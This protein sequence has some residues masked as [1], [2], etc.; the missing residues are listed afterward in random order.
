MYLVLQVELHDVGAPGAPSVCCVPILAEGGDGP[1]TPLELQDALPLEAFLAPV[2]ACKG[3]LV[4]AI[5]SLEA[6][7]P[8]NDWQPAA[9]S[10]HALLGPLFTLLQR[11]VGGETVRLHV[12]CGG[13]LWSHGL[14]QVG[15]GSGSDRGRGRAAGALA[16]R[17]RRSCA[18][19]AGAA[20]AQVG[21][22][23]QAQAR[24]AAAGQWAQVSRQGS[25]QT[26]Q[27]LQVGHRSTASVSVLYP[28]Y[29]PRS[30]SS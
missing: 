20:A 4:A 12:C 13:R 15:A 10:F 25:H 22:L 9:M 18:T 14:L 2:A 8:G 23:A 29:Q 3:S 30:C 5:E 28:L 11:A 19:W 26:A 24:G 27:G 21:C 1:P 17:C 16:A 7:E 6:Q